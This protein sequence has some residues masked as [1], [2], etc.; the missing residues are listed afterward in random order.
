M[1]PIM[2]PASFQCKKILELFRRPG[3]VLGARDF[4]LAGMQA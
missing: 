4:P 3:V 1:A 2:F